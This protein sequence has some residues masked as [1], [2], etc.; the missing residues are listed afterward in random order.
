MTDL[1]KRS[2]LKKTAAAA[3]V[4]PVLEIGTAQAAPAPSGM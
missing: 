2:F 4:L 1:S 3:A